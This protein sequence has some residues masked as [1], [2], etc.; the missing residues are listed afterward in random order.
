[1]AVLLVV[2]LS[3]TVSMAWAEE[4]SLEPSPSVSTSESPPPSSSPSPSSSPE[5]EV[6]PSSSLEPSPSPTAGVVFVDAA[7]GSDLQIWLQGTSLAV[8][9]LVLLV[10]VHVAGSW[11]KG[12]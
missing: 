8:V 11:G 7:P 9:V 6:E 10:A 1:M 4:S 2:C 5:P 12:S 3:G